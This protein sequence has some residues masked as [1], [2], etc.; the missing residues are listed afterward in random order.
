[1]NAERSVAQ[2]QAAEIAQLRASLEEALATR[3]GE[4][5]SEVA[6]LRAAL[7]EAQRAAAPLT[8]QALAALALNALQQKV[9]SGAP[10]TEELDVF[11]GLAPESPLG[12]RLAPLAAEGAPTLEALQESFGQAARDAIAAARLAQATD[13][14]SR[15]VAN[16]QSLVSVRT[17]TPQEGDGPIAVIS[18]AEAAVRG[19]D[20]EAAIAELSALEGPPAEAVANWLTK[21]RGMVEARS[22]LTEVNNALRSQF[23]N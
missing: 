20:I 4:A 17:I 23:R 6:S 2:A 11:V 14:V 3:E 5:A 7:G 19:G 12:L 13:P 22:A 15:F 21:A 10:F 8:R 9:I 1:M 18:R 16:L